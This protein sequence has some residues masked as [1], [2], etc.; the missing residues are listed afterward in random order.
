M[1]DALLAC[2][3][4]TTRLRAWILDEHGR[5]QRG[6][7]FELGVGRLQPGEAAQR[8]ESEVRPSLKAPGLPALLCGMVGSE[9]GWRA[10]P[11]LACPARLED[12]SARR[13]EVAPKV[14]IVPGLSC[15]GLAG[16]PDVMR[17]EETQVFGWLTRDVRRARG[18]QLICHP[19]T[20]AKWIVAE[21]GAVVRFATAM[22][23]ELFDLLRRHSVLRSP[24]S[25]GDL[26]A[27][28]EGVEVGRSGLLLSAA[29]FTLR[30]R[31]ATGQIAPAAAASYLSGILIGAE[32]AAMP[33]LMSPSPE[34]VVLIGAP[35]LNNAYARALQ[36]CGVRAE[37]H[38][39][40]EAACAGLFAIASQAGAV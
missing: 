7:T 15:A 18:R 37:I 9:L 25:P 11:H 36:A 29:V 28:E 21:D 6:A 33:R 14:W 5:V 23:G 3:W 17:G 32:V 10:V 26:T 24:A 31:V 30:G 16:V 13:Q 22:T 2:D 1:A 38:D 8:F 12:L 39:G 20:H 4:G 40:E 27:F 19:G 35:G 34:P